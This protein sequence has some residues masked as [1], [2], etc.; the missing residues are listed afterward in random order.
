MKCLC[1]IDS[2]CFSPQHSLSN[3]PAEFI[4]FLHGLGWIVDPVNHPGFPGKIR[5]S[6]SEDAN[7]PV[8]I[9][10]QIP[11][12]PFPYFADAMTEVAFIIPTLKPSASDSST[13][14]RSAE[15]SDSGGQDVTSSVT[16]QVPGGVGEGVSPPTSLPA[17]L[18]REPQGS[19]VSESSIQAGEID[20]HVTA[21]PRGKSRLE[22]VNVETPRRRMPVPQDCAII[23]VWLEKFED[24]VNFP[25]ETMSNILHGGSLAA[26]GGSHKPTLKRTL[27]VLFIHMLSSGLYQIATRATS[28][29]RSVSLS[30]CL[31][32]CQSVCLSVCL[33][34]CQSVCL[35][36]YPGAFHFVL[37]SPLLTGKIV[38]QVH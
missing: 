21:I 1:N 35:S 11:L 4:E 34:V 37:F 26:F 29:S 28:S 27:P 9:D 8:G 32:V 19:G 7:R 23:V 5:A 24:H 18:M 12:R 38:W 2:S 13:S 10:A 36:V 25:L 30:V 22:V 31:S 14:L 16:T 20:R 33:S 3:K 15:S 6:K 17:Q